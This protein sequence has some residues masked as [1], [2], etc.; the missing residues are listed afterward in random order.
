MTA[1]AVLLFAFSANAQNRAVTGAISAADSEETLPGAAVKAV[2]ITDSTVWFGTA[3]GPDGSFRVVVAQPGIYNLEVTYLG[4]ERF[5]QTVDLTGP[6]EVNVD[7]I[8]LTVSARTLDA[9]NVSE[10]A[11]RV[12]LEGDTTNYN[13]DAFKVNRDADTRKLLEKMPG[14]TSGRDGVSVQGERVQRV[15]VDGK[16]FFGNDPNVALNTIPAE[17]VDRIQVY[18]QLSEQSQFSGFNDGN[19]IKTVNIITKAGKNKGEFGKVFAGGGTDGRYLAGGNVNIFDGDRRI[20]VLGLANNVNQVNFATEDI[21][22]AIGSTSEAINNPRRWRRGGGAGTGNADD[23]LV[24]PQNGI[25]TATALGLNFSDQVGEKLKINASYLFNDTENANDNSVQRT[26]LRGQNEGQTYRETAEERSRNTNHRFN[27]RAEY[28]FDDRNSLLVRPSVGLQ[29]FSGTS[30]QRFLTAA[31]DSIL[32]AG[33]NRNTENA[34][35][36]SFSN[37]VLYKHKFKQKGQTFSLSVQNSV[38]TTDGSNTLRSTRDL[39]DG[40]FEAAEDWQA[41]RDLASQRH[42]MNFS[43][44]RPLGEKVSLEVGYKPEWEQTRSDWDTRTPDGANDYVLIDSALSN[45]FESTFLTHNL[46]SRLRI[47]AGQGSFA[48]LGVNYQYVENENEQTFPTAFSTDRIY[49]NVLPFA[50]FRKKFE[51]KANLFML[52]RA[53]ANLPSMRQLNTVIDN[54]NPFQ[55]NVGNS[56]LEQGFGHRFFTRFSMTNE[57]KGTNFFVFASGETQADR[58]SNSTFIVRQDTT[59]GNGFVLPAGGQI[60]APINLDG[61]RNLRVFS[62]YGFPVDLIKSNLNVNGTFNYNRAPGQVN[63]INNFTDNTGFN[64]GVVLGSNIS[65]RVDFKMGG[66][67]GIN[68]VNNTLDAGENFDYQTFSLNTGGVFSPKG[69]WVIS[70]DLVYNVFRGLGDLDQ[71]FLLWNAGLGYRFLKDESLELR[72][73]GFDLLGQNNSVQRSITETFTE[74]TETVVLQRYLMVSLSYRLRNFKGDNRSQTG[75]Q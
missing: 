16:E 21:A 52:Y 56:N 36:L 43:Y 7:V 12:T 75:M 61:Y 74:D 32:N 11:A 58:I 59:L 48:V 68:W 15:L 14:V 69:R 60:T 50:L 20:S 25:N 65:E 55:V 71:E 54:S 9:V 19:T 40:V 63:G 17:I 26:F 24:P 62:N 8:N 38:N 42:S 34:R 53:S 33:T 66:D 39:G 28:D 51:N 41:D 5:R 29:N 37:E 18:D 10:R 72:L 2:S 6:G 13:A 64:L 31:A 1:A 4:Y 35:S 67:A 49:R 47:N 46:R 73:T 44:T 30:D 23:F 57:E 27:L 22:G 45:A 70:T 3:S